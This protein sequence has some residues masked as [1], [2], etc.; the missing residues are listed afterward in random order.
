MSHSCLWYDPPG[1]R[2]P[3]VAPSSHTSY[4]CYNFCCHDLLALLYV[5][6][7]TRH[8]SYLALCM[9][10]RWKCTVLLFNCCVEFYV[11]VCI[12]WY[13]LLWQRCCY[14]VVWKCMSVVN[15]FV[16]CV[17]WFALCMMLKIIALYMYMC[18]KSCTYLFIWRALDPNLFRL[19]D[20]VD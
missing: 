2:G 18:G 16:S 3:F 15:V 13:Y 10:C 14:L 4:W 8:C 7:A 12:N 17:L 20:F 1:T 5:M 9:L 11:C 19:T 6:I